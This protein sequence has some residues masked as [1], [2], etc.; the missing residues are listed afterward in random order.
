MESQPAGQA[1]G[2]PGAPGDYWDLHVIKQ[3]YDRITEASYE[4]AV[5]ALWLSILSQY[6]TV[7]QGYAI[8]AQVEPKEGSRKRCNITVSPFHHQ[9]GLRKRIICENKRRSS[10]NDEKVWEAARKQ[11]RGYLEAS[12]GD[13][14]LYA[15][16]GIGRLV[17]FY[18]FGENSQLNQLN[19]SD[20][21]GEVDEEQS[22][23]VKVHHD[24]I[25]ALLI[26]LRNNTRPTFG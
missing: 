14:D 3:L 10:E 26:Q 18:R 7:Q 9:H 2:V 11:V 17:R 16:V 23:D 5:D 22:W 24:K 25:H 21:V 19:K 13:E 1:L 6:F 20:E 8:E 12:R 15:I 4:T